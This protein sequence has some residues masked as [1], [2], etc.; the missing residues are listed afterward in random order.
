MRKDEEEREKRVGC[1]ITKTTTNRERTTKRQREEKNSPLF[2]SLSLS[3]LPQVPG[4]YKIRYVGQTTLSSAAVF[5]LF[6]GAGSLL[7]CGRGQG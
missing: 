7:H 1:G 2:L 6:L 4:V 5:G 3:F